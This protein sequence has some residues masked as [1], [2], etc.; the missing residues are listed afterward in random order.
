LPFREYLE[1]KWNAKLSGDIVPVGAP[2]GAIYSAHRDWFLKIRGFEGHRVWGSLEVLLALRSYVSGGDCLIDTKSVFGH[3][4]KAAGSVK[5]VPDLIFNKL[6]I[7]S[8]LL[9]PDMEKEVYDWAAKMQRGRQAIAMIKNEQTLV[10]ILA[11]FGR[12]S[13]KLMGNAGGMDEEELRRR[14]KR[15]G[16]LD[17]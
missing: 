17:P 8:T 10:N 12:N 4:F 13:V 2:L 14:I 5:P 3:I 7:A 9:P 1:C 11:D 15:T 16:I 6:L